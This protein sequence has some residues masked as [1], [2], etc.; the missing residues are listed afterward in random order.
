MSELMELLKG[1]RTYRRFKQDAVPE[2]ALKDIL[3]AARISSCGANRQSIRYVVVQKRED[4]EQINAKVHWAAFLSREEA[5]P[6]PDELPT[7]F[8]AVC[9]DSSVQGASEADLGI[10][11]SNMCLA[12]YSHG[13]GSCMM[14][15]IDRKSIGAY[16]KLPEGISLSYMVAFGYP[17]HKSLIVPVENGDKKYRLDANKDYLVPKLETKDIVT[18]F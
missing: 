13:I 11:M 8:I 4:I 6:A 7:L 14:G 9:Q 1:C 5:A 2:E 18:Y 12:A 16:L 17:A 3:E 10:A 15:A